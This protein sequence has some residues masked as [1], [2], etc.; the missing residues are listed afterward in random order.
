MLARGPLVSR[1]MAMGFGSLAGTATGFGDVCRRDPIAHTAAA[2]DVLAGGRV[3]YPT[4]L[5]MAAFLDAA[6]RVCMA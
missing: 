3:F 5:F 4:H 1:G 6:G 2:M